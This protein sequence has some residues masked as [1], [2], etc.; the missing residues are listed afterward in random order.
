MFISQRLFILRRLNF[1]VR[2]FFRRRL[3]PLDAPP[4]RLRPLQK[5]PLPPQARRHELVLGV[6]AQKL[7]QLRAQRLGALVRTLPVL[8]VVG[9]YGRVGARD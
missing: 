6:S 5:R 9:G 4:R 2:L 1:S 7:P 3:R 8:A